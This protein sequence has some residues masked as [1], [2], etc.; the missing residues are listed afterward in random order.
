MVTL[1]LL[2][3]SYLQDAGPVQKDLNLVHR[4]RCDWVV[5]QLVLETI[6]REDELSCYFRLQEPLLMSRGIQRLHEREVLSLSL[7]I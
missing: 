3:T 5:N 7:S 4:M 1:I 6:T 2:N